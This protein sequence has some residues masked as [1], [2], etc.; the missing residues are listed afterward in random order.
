MKRFDQAMMSH[1]LHKRHARKE[2]VLIDEEISIQ[3]QNELC[4]LIQS[5]LDI[6][7]DKSDTQF[8]ATRQS[9]P[10]GMEVFEM[11]VLMIAVIE[12]DFCKY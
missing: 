4:R 11:L 3:K 6:L 9:M 7:I 1:I 8:L 2:S 12:G 5:D 10:M